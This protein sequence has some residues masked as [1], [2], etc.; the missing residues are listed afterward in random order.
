MTCAE[1][2]IACI[3]KK[4]RCTALFP[5]PWGSGGIEGEG[6]GGGMAG[7]GIKTEDSNTYPIYLFV[8]FIVTLLKIGIY[9]L[10]KLQITYKLVLLNI[11]VIARIK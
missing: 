10:T 11:K 4:R 2:S 6:R 8:N 7:A 5:D 9:F 1:V 3:P